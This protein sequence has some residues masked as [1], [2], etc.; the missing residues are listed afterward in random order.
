MG[1]LRVALLVSRGPAGLATLLQNPSRGTAFDISIVAGSE[2]VLADAEALERAGIP[3]EIRPIR[4]RRS[5][6]NLREREDYDASL[7]DLFE[8]MEIDVILLAGYGYI[9]TGALLER[10]PGRV[11][12][13]HDADF[14]I[15]DRHTFGG[16]RAVR[17]A[18]LAGER[19][20]RSSIYV[21]TRDIAAGPLFL[22]GG[23]YPLAPMA[24]DARERGDATFLTAYAELHRCWMIASSW[25]QMMARAL[26]LLAASTTH[27]VG[28]VVWIDGAPGPC[29][30]GEAPHVC[31]EPE[32]MVVRGIPRSCPFIG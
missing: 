9:V 22:L 17:D 21:V 13:I 2:A 16:P 24:L 10:F 12:A 7:A 6:R 28:D 8:R 18:I 30:F 29:R 20:T 31:H 4:E 19:E 26:E 15:R 14:S 25:G 5:F 23:P 1:A 11:L 3:V 32:A 27:V